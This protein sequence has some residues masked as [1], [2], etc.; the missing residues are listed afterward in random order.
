MKYRLR[1]FHGDGTGGDGSEDM[2]VVNH[3]VLTPLHVVKISAPVCLRRQSLN[4]VESR[5]HA[6]TQTWGIQAL[7]RI[8]NGLHYRQVAMSLNALAYA[9]A[10]HALNTR[11]SVDAGR[12]HSV[13]SLGELHNGALVVF[14]GVMPLN[15]EV[16]ESAR[17]DQ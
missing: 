8:A 2:L 13:H 4:R 6:P 1:R 12:A 15:A 17:T 3:P 14:I 5:N 9:R 7:V 16:G 10:S 11:A